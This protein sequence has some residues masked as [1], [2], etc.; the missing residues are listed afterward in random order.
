VGDRVRRGQLLARLDTSQ[1]QPQIAE[2]RAAE[3]MAR[4][5]VSVARAEYQQS[6]EE[7][8]QAHAEF[9][10][11]QGALSDARAGVQAAD[12][13]REN[14]A[15]ELAAAQTQVADAAAQLEAAQ[16]DQT[17]SR[18]QIQ[19]SAALVKE[20][21]IS[22][23][24]FQREQAQA[25]NAE[26][27][28]RQAQARVNQVQA[29]VRAAQS[30]VR[31]AEAMIRSARAK[32]EQTVSELQ[33]HRAHV[34]SAHA[35][36]N[37]ARQRV[38]QA[39]AGVGQAQAAAAAAATTRGY[40]EIRALVDGVVTQRLISPGVLVNPG[41]GILKVVQLQPI[42]L[43]ANV[44]EADLS[45]I[46]VGAPV[47]A[48]GQNQ[49]GRP[50]AARVTS[51]TPAVD[52]VAR[53]G[54]VEALIPNRDLRFL[55]GQYVVMQ[56]STGRRSDVLR[57]PSAAIRWR[58]AASGGVLSTRTTPFVWLAE[59]SDREGE[60]V[61]RAVE[62]SRGLS[63]GERT[64]VLSGLQEGQRVVTA[65]DQYL[66]N[67]DTVTPVDGKAAS[68]SAAA[69]PARQRTS[70]VQQYT[71]PMHPEIV[72]DQPGKC[73]KCGMDLVPLKGQRR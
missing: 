72:R 34:R 40:S 9:G 69:S 10:Q 6:Q 61:V 7:M 13:E 71:C 33:A 31:K 11:R 16:A 57:V 1:V 30:G 36:V 19:R 2:R 73:P 41:Q 25:Q 22:G 27:K 37:A 24:E 49:A 20:G 45:R 46:R 42:R 50:V 63:D 56:I 21:A 44:A 14:A 29:Q 60:F 32:V 4:Q 47:T 23:E 17:Y 18:A 48:R 65:G 67:G 52:P 12:E 68:N 5:G 28:V 26:S 70:P 64:E 8:R 51:I 3:T 59:P 55:P 53:T 15:A 35:A 58:T 62:I 39:Q 43:Q 66:K 54:V 38:A